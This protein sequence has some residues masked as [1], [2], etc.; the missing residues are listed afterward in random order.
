[1]DASEDCQGGLCRGQG[2]RRSWANLGLGDSKEKGQPLAGLAFMVA[3]PGGLLVSESG[4]S[5]LLG[6]ELPSVVRRHVR[7]SPPPNLLH[8]N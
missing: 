7:R 8:F 4:H 6:R 3:A 5:G 2:L 1:M